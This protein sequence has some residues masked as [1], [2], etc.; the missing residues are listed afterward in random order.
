M[1]IPINSININSIKE[2]NPNDIANPTSA[3]A[4]SVSNGN[5]AGSF[6]NTLSGYID[7]VNNLQTDA[8]KQAELIASGKSS[9]I[10]QAMID[11]EKANDSF[12]LMMQMRNKIITAYNTVINM[13]V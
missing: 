3:A 13:Q 1:A 10:H 12:E 6:S 7:K 4:S 11:V 5:G 2:L 9:N 8:N